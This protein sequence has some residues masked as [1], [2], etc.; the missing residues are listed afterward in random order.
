[1]SLLREE[2]GNI[3]SVLGLIT[4]L[5]GFVLTYRQA[6]AAKTAGQAAAE[7]V[8]RFRRATFGERLKRLEDLITDVLSAERTSQGR[9]LIGPLVKLRKELI[10]CYSEPGLP[11]PDARMMK[12]SASRIA[13][14]IETIPVGIGESAIG[15]AERMALR[16]LCLQLERNALQLQQRW[17]EV[18][19]AQD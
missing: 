7:A 17:M 10:R 19:R 1:M 5:V 3:A 18:D 2:Y 16:Q 14:L 9:D 8:E 6:K 4:A 11:A 15:E 13:G 12:H